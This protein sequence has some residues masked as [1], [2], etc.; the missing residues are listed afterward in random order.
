MK[1]GRLAA[2]LALAFLFGGGSA[3]MAVQT[4]RAIARAKAEREVGAA[5]DLVAL[6]VHGEDGE[7]IAHPRLIAVA[8]KPAQ[9]VLLDPENPSLVRLALRVETAREP[10]GD[11]ALDWSL[12]LPGR[13]LSASGKTSVTPGIE[14]ALALG[15]VSAKV[16]ALP[17]PSA[18]FDA[19][20]EAQGLKNEPSAI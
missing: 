3:E 5:G 20:I 7:L 10:S 11:I 19:Y 15:D 4:T 13:E 12:E 2:L 16:L 1:P 18:A 6:E 9:L 8:G 14:Q 17:V